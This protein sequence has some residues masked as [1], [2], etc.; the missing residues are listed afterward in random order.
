MGTAQ[1]PAPD[2]RPVIPFEDRNRS[3]VDG[4]F[5]TV[6]LLATSPSEAFQRMPVTGGIGRPLLFAIA[7]G[8]IGVAVNVAWNVLFQGA[9]LPFMQNAND[10]AQM[11]AAYGFTIGWGLVV[12]VLAPLFIIIGV[13]VAAVVFHLMLLI[14]G[15]ASRDFETTVRVVCYTQTAQLAGI[16]PCCG[17]IIGLVWTIVLYTVGFSTAHQTSQGKALVAIFLP[18]VLCCAMTAIVF[19]V[20]GG[21]AGLAALVGSQ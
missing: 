1:P 12:A 14:V 20:A 10:V 19:V 6:K 7:I 8:W 4:L 3:V 21:L 11:G 2:T 16:I 15:G 18:V 5:E 9:W 17:S 13:F